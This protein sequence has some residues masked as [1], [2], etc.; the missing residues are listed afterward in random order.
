MAGETVWI[1]PRTLGAADAHGNQIPSWPDVGD[2]GAVQVNGAKVA[3]RTDLSGEIP[4]PQR[5]GVIVGA[6]VYLPAGFRLEAVDLMWV[7]GTTWEVVGEPGVW[8]QPWTGEE[9][10]VQVALRRRE[11]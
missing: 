5:E 6:T 4:S 9:K 2:A 7:R 8:V 11:G 10:G 1:L 3:P